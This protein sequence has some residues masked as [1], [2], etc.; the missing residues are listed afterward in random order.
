[1]CGRARDEACTSQP[2]ATLITRLAL[3]TLQNRLVESLSADAADELPTAE[4]KQ[5]LSAAAACLE[6]FLLKS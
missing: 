1:M 2:D 5:H 4:L 6:V 3:T